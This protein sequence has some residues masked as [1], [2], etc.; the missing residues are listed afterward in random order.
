MTLLT[1]VGLTC[2]VLVFV[3]FFYCLGALY[4]ERKDRSVLFWKSLPLSDAQTVLSKALWAL[5]VAPVAGR[6]ASASHVGIVLVLI[7]GRAL[8]ATAAIPDAAAIC[9]RPSASACSATCWPDPGLRAVGAADG[10]LA[11]AVLGLGAQQAVPVGGA[12]AGVRRRS[13]ISWFGTA[14]RASTSTHDWFWYTMVGRAPAEH[15]PGQLVPQRPHRRRPATPMH[16]RWPG[17]PG[18]M[19]SASTSSWH[20]FATAELWIGAVAG[21]VMIYAAI[22]LRRCRELAD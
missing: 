20:A 21:A 13:S 11:D 12:G 16:I 1:G 18:D 9:R 7:V 14:A 19:R 3:V 5:V 4:D 2:I 17:R 8:L 22:Q 10:R 15:R 6:R